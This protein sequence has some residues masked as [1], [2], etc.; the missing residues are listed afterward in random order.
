MDDLRIR[1]YQPDEYRSKLGVPPGELDSNGGE[2]GLEVAPV[3]KVPGAKE[4]G[5]QSPVRKCPLRNSL[6]DG[7]L[8][9]PSEPVQPVYGGLVEVAGPELDPVQNC[10]TRSAETSTAVAMSILG[11][12]CESYVVEDSGFG[13]MSKCFQGII[14]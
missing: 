14:V 5:S 7:A 12:L 4:G 2:D 10:C 1:L 13:C 8:A 6:R 11:L 3:L 9:R